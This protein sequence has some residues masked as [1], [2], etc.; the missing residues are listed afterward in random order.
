MKKSDIAMIVLI[1]S[2]SMIAAYFTVN[3]IPLFQA[4]SKPKAVSTF[5]AISPD[6]KD[7]DPEVFNAN[8]INPTV[9]VFIGGN[10]DQQ[11]GQ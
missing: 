3:S 2:I 6:V 5:E 1:A 10:E 7:V 8:A 11:A 9:E 4:S